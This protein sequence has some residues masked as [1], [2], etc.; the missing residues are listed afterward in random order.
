MATLV[1]GATV[2]SPA[3]GGAQEDPSGGREQADPDEAAL[4][5]VDIDVMKSDDTDVQEALTDISANVEAQVEQL[6]NA[7]ATV[8][9]A[10]EQLAAA[11]LAVAETQSRID[12][13]STQTDGIVINAF[14]NPPAEVALDAFAAESLTDMSVKQSILN[15]KATSDAETLEM[16]E[17]ARAQLDVQLAERAALATWA[18]RLRSALRANR[19]V[20]W[21]ALR[22]AMQKSASIATRGPLV[23]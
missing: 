20:S 18:D 12:T 23:P 11:D 6:A 13:L 15:S 21:S 16:Y 3:T 1:I 8:A 14:M 4:V 10:D 19:R 9:T 7:R 2:L 22:D 17:E 5:D